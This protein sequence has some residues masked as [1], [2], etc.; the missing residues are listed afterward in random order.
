MSAPRHVE[1]AVSSLGRLVDTGWLDRDKCILKI[2]RA[3]ATQ[4]MDRLE[5]EDIIERWG[6]PA[7]A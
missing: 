6:E 4:R 7:R 5:I 3:P 2:L 1:L